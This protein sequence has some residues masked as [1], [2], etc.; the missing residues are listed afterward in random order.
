MKAIASSDEI[1]L[2]LNLLTPLYKSYQWLTRSDIRQLDVLYVE[3]NVFTLVE[4]RRNAI[5]NDFMLWVNR[6]SAPVR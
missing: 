5:L 6:D 1:A 2:Q 4:A 3:K